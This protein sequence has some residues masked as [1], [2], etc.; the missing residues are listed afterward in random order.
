MLTHRRCFQILSVVVILATLFSGLLSPSASAQGSDGLERHV[1]AQTGKVSFLGGES[2]LP[3]PASRALG[4]GIARTQDPAGALAKH[5][6]PE[7][8]LKDPE[9]ELGEMKSSRGENGRLTVRY[10][11]NYQG[12]PVI[13]GELIV[14][15]N[16]N[17]DLY[18]M[19]G[20]VS[21]NLSLSTQPGIDSAQAKQTALTA[22]AKWYQKA[23]EDFTASEP[24]LWIY[25]ESLL[26]PSTR[27]AELV[28]RMQVTPKDGGMPVRELVL[29]DAHRGHINLHFNQID[30]AWSL[31]E[32]SGAIREPD[33]TPTAL[34]TETPPPAETP[35]A[36]KTV[37]PTATIAQTEELISTE[38]VAVPEGASG[39]VTTLAGASWY[40]TTSGNDSNSCASAGSPCATINS[41]IAKAAAGDTIKVAQGVYTGTGDYVVIVNNNL[42]LSG[43]WNN[44]FDS[45]TGL[46]TI[47]GQNSR[48]GVSNRGTGSTIDRFLIING[49]QVSSTG[50]AGGITS[51]APLILNNSIVMN[52]K[53][54]GG[55]ISAGGIFSNGDLTLNYSTI[56]NNF[57]VN[58]AA[59]I[60]MFGNG[61]FTL[62]NSTVAENHAGR[63]GGGIVLYGDELGAPQVTNILNSTIVNNT[64]VVSAGGIHIEPRGGGRVVT[65]KNSILA[66]NTS[67]TQGPDCLGIVNTLDHS[68]IGNITGCTVASGS[69]NLLNKDPL[70]STH[71]VGSQGYYYALLPASPAI[72]TGANCLPTD[73]RGL[74]RPQGA[75]CDIGAYEFTVPGPAA[76]FGVLSGSNQTAG[77]WLPFS[78]RLIVYV[79]DA[80][81]NPVS[82]VNV[83]FTAPASGASGIFAENGTRS[84]TTTTDD[85]GWAVA[86]TLTANSQN[87]TYSVSATVSGLP[88]S[89]NFA[90]KNATWYVS[91]TGNNTNSCASP[92]VPCLSISGAIGKA[93]A[94]DAI[95]VAVGTYSETSSVMVA[96]IT[97]SLTL[98]GGWNSL[99][100]SNIGKST[101]DGGGVTGVR[102]DSAD[103]T[104]KVIISG[105]IVKNSSTGIANYKSDLTFENGA[106]IN[107]SR[108]LYNWYGNILLTN[109]TISGNHAQNTVGS[110]ISTTAGVVR[111]QYSTITNNA[112]LYDRAVRTSS[113]SALIEISDSILA[114]NSE[115]DCEGNLQS[116][117]HNIF[118]SPQICFVHG[119]PYVVPDPTDQVGVDPKLFPLHPGGY[120]PLLPNSPAVNAANSATCPSTDQRGV[121]RPADT[122]C[123]IG[124]FEHQ[125]P[126]TVPAFIL[127]YQGTP[128]SVPLGAMALKP[129]RAIVF[130]ESGNLVPGVNVTFTAPGSGASG[131][132]TGTSTNQAYATTNANGVAVSPVFTANTVNGN[133]SISASAAGVIQSASFQVTNISQPVQTYD[134]Y[135]TLPLPGMILCTETTMNCTGGAD[136][137]AHKAHLYA[138]GIANFYLSK[139]NRGGIDRYGMPVISSVHYCDSSDVRVPCPYPNAFWNGEQIV[140]GDAYG[141][142]MADD[143]VAHEFSHGVTQY[144]SGLFYYYQSGAIN[145]SFSDLWGE[146][147]DQTNA[148][149]NDATAVKWLIGENVTGLGA[150]RSMSNPPS[151]NDPD[152]M[153]SSLYYKGAE[154][155]G[156]IHTNSG[157][158]NKAVYL[159]VNGGTFNGKTV[160]ALGWEK[161]SSI[162]YEA[163]TNLLSS[164]ADYSDLYYALQRACTNLIGQKGITTGNCAEVRDAIDTVEMNRQPAS[165]FNPDAP[166][167]TTVGTTPKIIFADDLETGVANWTFANLWFDPAGYTRWQWDSPYHVFAQSGLHSLYADDYPDWITDATAKLK[168]LAIPSNAYLH[169]A[170]AYD[171]ETGKLVNDPTL[172]YFDGG[173]LEYSINNGSTWL[174]AGSLIDYNGYR[175]KIFN[176]FDPLLDNNPLK[177]RSA[178]VGTSHGYISTRLNLASLAGKTVT[179]RW[180]MGLDI[181][182]SAWGWWVDNVKIYTCSIPPPAAFNKASPPHGSIGVGL[183]TTL[184]WSNSASASSYQYCYDTVDDNQCNRTWSG[185]LTA[186]SA[187][188]SNLGP[189]TTYYWQVRAVNAGGTTYAD[190]QSWGS[191]ATT[192]TLPAS[193]A[194]INTTISTTNYGAYSLA[195]GQSLRESYGVSNGPVKIQS[196]NDVPLIGAER[197]IYKVNNVNTSFTEMMALP[198]NQLDTI[199][200]LPWYNNIEL[201]TQL[202][203]A[204]VSATDGTV[205]VY[206]GGQKIGESISLLAGQSTRISFPQISNGPVRIE[207]DLDIVASERV[208]YKV[209]NTNT[210]FSEMMALPNNQLDTIYW[211]PWYNNVDLDTQLRVANVTDQPATVDVTIGGQPVEGGSFTLLPGESVRKS[212]PGVSSGPVKVVSS[213]NIVV[214]ERVIYKVNTVNTSFSEMMALPNKQ[215]D[216]TFW[217]PWYNNVDLDTQLRFAN[218]GL[219]DGT[220]HIFIGGQE[221]GTGLPLKAGESTRV[222]FPQISSGPVQIVSDVDIVAAERVIYKVNNVNT[223]FSEMM[224]LPDKLLDAIYWLPWYNNIDLDTQLRF[225]VP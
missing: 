131:I 26:R 120:H 60:L 71:P 132:F 147:Y 85:S 6:G 36:A 64:A 208:I 152:K 123:D 94:G 169:F 45:Q 28:W 174:D 24:E 32:G 9:R 146:Y 140:Y 83:T 127:A 211:L 163:N 188:I 96:T 5:F 177:G 103:N 143:V 74:S 59:G 12:I 181:Y 15:T 53:S 194:A 196:T 7:F 165:G 111:I 190:N 17:G 69:G 150:T 79:V 76:S 207:S 130:D 156:G 8:G 193:T 77:A 142:A 109:T 118:G 112:G 66:K 126:G 180:R 39:E 46:S 16:R 172:Y 99:F 164:G 122:G 110:A 25:D 29:V 30:T 215:V 11:Q 184:S 189:S 95:K 195:R 213:Q 106:L 197:L 119:G 23:P 14:N 199:Y 191:F 176:G 4:I 50:W 75:A 92:A 192:S 38:E 159:M 107:N 115:Y 162:Y 93:S 57:S 170:H 134:V 153:S 202:R 220:V 19:N 89:A 160:T 63:Q 216:K 204:N 183:N 133:Y 35:I 82:D 1:N 22:L 114:G 102:I 179:F 34:P 145:E 58:K 54:D 78:E 27:P 212:F 225:A 101:I 223:S 91:P 70:V 86:S 186:T 144:E 2:G 200:W 3:L 105:F 21:S 137:H 31:N 20:E 72:D 151:Y 182:G 149:G 206:I 125:G 221:M 80:W 90:L 52:N 97:K 168:S 178:F 61:T 41:A 49:Y 55:S 18:S 37:E 40:V 141:F 33:V 148:L 171:F 128:Q 224:G 198:N 84:T 116:L 201:D 135:S 73:Q 47:D 154:D 210:S 42:T 209:N 124:S 129:F 48:T 187:S 222:S 139:H 67:K 121:S 166:L 10:Q 108:G 13:G 68:L 56:R 98:S 203:F 62:N 100:S 87:G 65:I 167:C 136:P 161:T 138:I 219:T 217:F 157:V 214:S 185:P 43:G 218:V 205:D 155:N 88:G 113:D 173:V 104:V 175:G 81:G 51:S 158:N 44:T 117:G